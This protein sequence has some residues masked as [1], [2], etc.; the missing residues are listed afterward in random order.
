[1]KT[2]YSDLLVQL[3]QKVV[4]ELKRHNSF[5]ASIVA[6]AINNSIYS[7]SEKD[8]KHFILYA[9]DLLITECNKIK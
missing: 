7:M 5:I 1:M 9:K 8:A 2:P 4:D 3:S 6:P